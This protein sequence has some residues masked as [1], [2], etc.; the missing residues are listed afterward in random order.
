MSPW[1]IVLRTVYAKGKEGYNYLP[2][3]T[4]AMR[5]IDE[6]FCWLTLS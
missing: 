1:A 5:Y 2:V 3:R 6:G 4:C